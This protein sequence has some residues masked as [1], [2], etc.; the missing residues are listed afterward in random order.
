MK[1]FLLDD[2]NDLLVRDDTL[3]LTFTDENSYIL[4]KIKN[5]LLFVK[6]E[7]FLNRSLGLPYFTVILE[8]GVDFNFI[9]LLFR[10]EILN[11]NGITD[12]LE[13]NVDV[14]ADRNF[15]IAFKIFYNGDEVQGEVGV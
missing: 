9:V 12:I 13:F 4:Q 2:S 3:N 7:W 11:I 6:N 14:S 1:S 5:R 8:K 15:N 10:Q